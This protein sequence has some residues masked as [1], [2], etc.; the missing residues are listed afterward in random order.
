MFLTDQLIFKKSTIYFSTDIS[1]ISG[2]WKD[3]KDDN[4]TLKI[5]CY[6]RHLKPTSMDSQL[7]YT[8]TDTMFKGYVLTELDYRDKIKPFSIG[9]G[10]INGREL[11]VQLM[12][13]YESPHQ[14]IVN[15]IVGTKIQIK[16]LQD[17]LMEDL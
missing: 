4:S 3:V 2:C 15:D 10:I 6:L 14:H 7:E 16:V 5:N 9:I 17:L 1:D 12:P 8:R 13:S 11:K